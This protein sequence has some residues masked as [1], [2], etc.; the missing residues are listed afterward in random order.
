MHLVDSQREY[1]DLTAGPFGPVELLPAVTCIGAFASTPIDPAR[2]PVL[3]RSALTVI[4][5]QAAPGVPAE[6]DT[7]LRD[8]TWE[9]TAQDVEL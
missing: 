9:D 7:A 4:W 5:F 1:P 3:Y 6:A 2:N 8:I